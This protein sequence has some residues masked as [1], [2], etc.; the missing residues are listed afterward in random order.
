MQQLLQALLSSCCGGSQD[1][2]LES[3]G[4]VLRALLSFCAHMDDMDAAAAGGAG[5]GTTQALA[6]AAGQLLLH[7]EALG[8]STPPQLREIDVQRVCMT[9][10]RRPP[11]D[12][13]AF[14]EFVETLSAVSQGTAYSPDELERFT[15]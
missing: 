9:L 11:L 13:A 14:G 8:L 5:P 1:V 12:E 7:P 10:G 3:S 2:L 15:Q 4:G 6:L